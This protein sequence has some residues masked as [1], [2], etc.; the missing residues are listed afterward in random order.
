M[1]APQAS[2]EA[3]YTSDVDYGRGELF[4]YPVMSTQALA[5]IVS[6]D[7]SKVLQ[8][9]DSS[10]IIGDPCMPCRNHIACS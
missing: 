10:A 8:V 3:I 2:G 1:G 6:I 7:G 4:A 9:T 5:N